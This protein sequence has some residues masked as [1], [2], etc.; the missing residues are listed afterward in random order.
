MEAFG[1]AAAFHDTARELVNDLDLAV[2]G[3]HVVNIAMEQVFGLQRLL[4]VVGE[5]AC[6]VCVDVIDTECRLDALQADLGCVDRAFGLVHLIIDISFET[7][8][9]A[10]E[11]IVR[12][13]C[14]GA[15]A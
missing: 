3:D 1:P 15:S 14:S 7:A 5:R 13:R 4:Q 10:C 2:F 12:A 9:S 6:S 8:D 11:V